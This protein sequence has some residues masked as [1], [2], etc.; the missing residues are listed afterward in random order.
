MRPGQALPTALTVTTTLAALG[1][2]P[3][4]P[5]GLLHHPGHPPVTLT[6]T[7]LQRLAC[8]AALS[9]VI[10]DAHR[11]PIGASHT[12]RTATPR[13][14]RT[15]RALWGPHCATHGCAQTATVPHHV[16]PYTHSKE[17]VLRDLVP[18]C[19][20][21]HHDIHDGR[22]TITLR[23]GRRINDTGWVAAT[24]RAA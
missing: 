10:L 20:S 5:P 18:L 14:R 13:E 1:G 17:T 22:R 6:T 16:H 9:A 2:E 23:T 19:R 3:G 8:N 15:L 21:C 4:A 12:A 11:N 24:A 7:T